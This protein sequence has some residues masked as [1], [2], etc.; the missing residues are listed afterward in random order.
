MNNVAEDVVP[1]HSFATYPAA[2]SL[3]IATTTGAAL[4]NPDV[5]ATSYLPVAGFVQV[6]PD[7]VIVEASEA[8]SP[9]IT[10]NA[11]PPGPIRAPLNATFGKAF[12]RAS[13]FCWTFSAN[14]SRV[15]GFSNAPPTYGHGSWNAMTHPHA[16]Q[17]VRSRQ[18]C[19]G[20]SCR[21]QRATRRT[22]DPGK[23]AGNDPT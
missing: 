4:N 2:I 22:N 16:V 8:T 13:R 15:F 5:N 21:W 14:S 6:N 19:E 11:F 23:H 1:V 7:P 10:R 20:K 12:A 9:A 3:T 17:A 18:C